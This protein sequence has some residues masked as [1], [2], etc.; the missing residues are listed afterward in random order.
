[1]AA[2][3]GAAKASVGHTEAASGMAGVLKATRLL[4]G[5]PVACGN[6]QLRALNPLVYERLGVR[7]SY[8]ALPTSTVPLAGATDACGVNSFGFSGTIVHALVKRGGGEVAL[9]VKRPSVRFSRQSFTWVSTA[10]PA[11]A[12][13]TM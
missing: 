11:S 3:V 12:R 5:E 4:N 2:M 7:A 1:M 6:A 13:L 8:F 10:A 9:P